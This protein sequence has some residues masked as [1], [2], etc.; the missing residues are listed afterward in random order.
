M[1]RRPIRVVPLSPGRVH[2]AQPYPP[3]RVLHGRLALFQM[4]GLLRCQRPIGNTVPD[5]LLLVRFAAIDLVHSRMSRIMNARSRAGSVVGCGLR[6]SGTDKHQSPHRKN[7][8]HIADFVG[9]ASRKP[10]AKRV[11]LPAD[12]GEVTKVTPQKSP[13]YV[14][15]ALLP[16]AFAFD[17]DDV[18]RAPR[19]RPS[20]LIQAQRT[21]STITNSP[22]QTNAHHSAHTTSRLPQGTAAYKPRPERA[23]KTSSAAEW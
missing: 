11:V 5:A 19:P 3:S 20:T 16:A 12:S 10:P 1:L 21:P 8:E 15:R 2:C 22:P 6:S 17:L 7:C 13:Q 23:S 9:H 18:A 4:R 14:E